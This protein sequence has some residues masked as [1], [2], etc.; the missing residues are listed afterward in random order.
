MFFQLGWR[1]IW[2]NRRRTLV[3]LTAVVIGV[4]SMIFLSSLMRGVADQFISNGIK[5]LTGHIQV[6]HTGYR[7][8]PVVENSIKDP[9]GVE[10]VLTAVLP[11]EAQWAPRV[12]VNAVASN[13][14]HSTG[15]TMVGIDPSQEAGVSFIGEAITEG[16]YLKTADPYGIVVG[17]AL[18][19]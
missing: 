1:N 15:I 5:T 9:A 4:W 2:R 18:V 10:A 7:E 6:H 19:K 13:A 14:R 8:D 3:I 17:K 12:R 16:R 11:P